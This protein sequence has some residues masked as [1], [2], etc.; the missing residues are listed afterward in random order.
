MKCYNKIYKFS[1]IVVLS[2]ILVCSNQSFSQSLQK[3]FNSNAYHPVDLPSDEPD[4]GTIA[5]GLGIVGAGALVA[6]LLP[7]PDANLKL[8]QDEIRTQITKLSEFNKPV[9]LN[10]EAENKYG[11]IKKINSD[12]IELNESNDV[13]NINDINFLIDLESAAKI[14]RASKN[15]WALFMAAAGIGICVIASSSNSSGVDEVEDAE[16]LLSICF[17]VPVRV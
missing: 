17:T 16:N 13:N 7:S 8:N 15:K 5:I 9:K 3:I 14:D 2:M 1:F 6:I 11:L 4:M 12:Q 10:L